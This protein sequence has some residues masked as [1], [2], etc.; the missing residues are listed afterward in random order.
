MHGSFRSIENTQNAE[1]PATDRVDCVLIY[2]PWVVLEG[3]S[4]LTNCLPP[5]SILS[6]AAYLEMKGFAVKVIDVH[7]ERMSPETLIDRLRDYNPR[8]VGISVL[9]S[10]VVA[11]H[12][13]AR[14]VKE[15]VPDCVVV[16][17]GVHAEIEP[18]RMLQNSS[19]DLVVRGDGERPMASIV[20]GEPWDN[21][22]SVTFVL[23]NGT[24][25]ENPPQPVE[26]DL[27]TY[28]MPAYHLVDFNR[29]FPSATSYRNLPAINIIMTRGCPGK[30]TFCNSADTILR[31]RS[32]QNVFEQI[33]LLR[34]RY[35][36]K[37]VQFFDDT[38]TVNKTGV[39]ELCR[40]LRENQVNI[41]FCCYI[42]G[43]CF[44]EEMAEALKSAGCHQVFVGI[45]TGSDE[46]SINIQKPISRDRYTKA[47]RIAHDNDM[48]VRAGFIIGNIGETWDTMEESLQF[49][50]D[51]D[52]DFFQLSIN[53]PYPGTALYNQALEEG[54]LKHTE[55]KHYGQN[56]AILKLDDLTEK[57]I[58][59]FDK[60]AWKRFYLRKRMIFRQLRRISNWRHVKDLYNAFLV[61][62]V[63]KVINPN[64]NWSKWD[65]ETEEA[66]YDRELSSQQRLGKPPL[67]FEVR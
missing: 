25:Y 66:Q 27:D 30:C 64:P 35:G 52:V 20:A 51:L 63:N 47:I 32:P 2:P 56:E 62:I 59:A 18:W 37:Q 67:T 1:L 54:R 55:F 39:L 36:I 11:A 15:Q 3:R 9:A 22:Q 14:L 34:E 53:T 49:A 43:D 48:E 61:L 40:L 6:I 23:P 26:M 45:E 38:F 12:S 17:G 29:Y 46:I 21:I 60:H 31:S 13:I 65:Q 16:M 8:Y 24:V 44:S 4:F 33:K 19:V 5:L 58:L 7:A 50:I 41:T 42:R 28:P 10:M 57:D